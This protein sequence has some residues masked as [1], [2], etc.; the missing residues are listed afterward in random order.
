MRINAEI[1]VGLHRGLRHLQALTELLA[2]M[3]NIRSTVSARLMGYERL[4]AP[5]TR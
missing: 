2:T 5:P 1:D 3:A 4:T